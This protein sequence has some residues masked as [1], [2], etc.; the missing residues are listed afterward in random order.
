MGAAAKP[1]CAPRRGNLTDRAHRYRANR[2]VS[3]PKVCGYCGGRRNLGVDHIDGHEEHGEPENLMW[4]CKPCNV[5]KANTM[6]AAGMG[7]LTRQYNPVKVRGA[8][9]VEEWLEA[10]SLIT[11]HKDHG[12]GLVT[13]I[14]TKLSVSDAVARVRATS[15]AKRSEFA[16]ELRG[17]GAGRQRGNPA[18]LAAEVFEEFHGYEPAEIVTVKR[19]VHYHKYLAAAGTLTRLVVL[20]VD[21]RVHTIRGFK[22]ALL[23]FNEAKNQLFIEGGDQSL[24]L[25][26]YGLSEPHELE[27]IGKVKVIDYR[28]NKT[29]LG[30]QG[31][32]AIYVHKFRTTNENGRHVVVT[33]KRYPTL[34]YRVLDQQFEF[35]GGSYT[36]RREGIDY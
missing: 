28:A 20:G 17:K 22:G 3:G 8:R 12:G 4:A 23:A 25:E 11:P 36:I 33:V 27:E 14:G 29:H 6:R 1:A 32:D 9:N 5:L 7:R 18:E 30:D 15:K 13:P 35:A 34:I 31:G 19:Q 10:V 26:D 21:K 24:N 16:S 2:N